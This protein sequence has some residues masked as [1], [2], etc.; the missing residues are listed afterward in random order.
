MKS[1]NVPSVPW[2]LVNVE[3]GERYA[4]GAEELVDAQ[5]I[6]MKSRKDNLRG[7]SLFRYK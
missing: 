4:D 5:E 6:S 7:V 3:A 1:D 2:S